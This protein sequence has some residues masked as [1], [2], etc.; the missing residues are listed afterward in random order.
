MTVDH[1]IYYYRQKKNTLDVL[2]VH[3]FHYY[4]IAA[5]A[6]QLPSFLQLPRH[7]LHQIPDRYL[8]RWDFMTKTAQLSDNFLGKA[9][10]SIWFR[11]LSMNCTPLMFTVFDC[12]NKC[13]LSMPFYKEYY[14]APWFH[15]VLKSHL[16][17]N[18]L[19]SSK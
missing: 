8:L 16:I 9:S 10:H 19:H 13:F 4:C 6:R 2:P 14:N 5:H 15:S 3:N 11:Y 17:S 18:C 7:V 12:V 1:F